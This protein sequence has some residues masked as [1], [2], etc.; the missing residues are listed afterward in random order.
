MGCI[1][2]KCGKEC[3][4]VNGRKLHLKNCVGKKYCKNCGLET[5]NVDYCDSCSKKEDEYIRSKNSY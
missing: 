4:T 5:T 1:C 3:K 2:Y